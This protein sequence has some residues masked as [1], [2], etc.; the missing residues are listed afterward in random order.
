MPAFAFRHIKDLY[1]IFWSKTR[2]GISAISASLGPSG[3]GTL[4]IGQWASRITLDIIGVAGLGRDFRA[5]Y[6]PSNELIQT[7]Q[8]I[9]VPSRQARVLQFLGFFVPHW[10]L[11]ALPLKRNQEFIDA[12]RTIK[13]VAGD[14]VRSKK[15]ILQKGGRVD[16]DILSVAIESGGFSDEDLVNQL[17]T[18]LAAGHE[19][20][21]S[22][23]MWLTYVLSTHQDVQRR[24]REEVRANLPSL[25]DNSAEI[26]PPDIDRMSYLHAVCN[27]VLR[28]WPPVPITLRIAARDTTVAGYHIPKDTTVVLPI[29]AMN[30]NKELWGDDAEE[31]NP[32]RWMGPGRANTGGADSNYAFMTFLHGPRSCIGSSFAKSEFAIIVAGLVGS[33]EFS[34]NDPDLKLEI[35]GGLTAKPKGGLEV[36][37]KALE[38]W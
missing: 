10:I 5:I 26:S 14:L 18:F 20:T 6:D 31:F 21:A 7:Y 23:V 35:Q 12:V 33:F 16:P 27:E 30:T 32:E 15:E 1:P 25:S 13:G 38:G 3:A 8:T 19:T 37:I 22:A 9:F 4:E 34:L 2:E 11:A 36:N 17:M 24:L 29:W 28:L